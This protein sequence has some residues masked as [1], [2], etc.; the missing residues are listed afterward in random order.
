MGGASL[1]TFHSSCPIQIPGGPARDSRRRL[2]RCR[3]DAGS[4]NVRRFSDDFIKAETDFC[5]TWEAGLLIIQ[6]YQAT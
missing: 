5:Q 2:D 3:H 4:P 6:C 1:A